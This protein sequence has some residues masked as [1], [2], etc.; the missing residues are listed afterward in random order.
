MGPL[1]NGI[2]AVLEIVLNMIQ[3]LVIA[4]IIVSWVGADQNN[5]F[6]RIIQSMT[7]PLF[8]PL[9]KFTKALPGPIDWAP[10]ILLLLI[11]FIQVGVIPYIRMMGTSGSPMGIP[12]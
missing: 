5:Q 10:M 8:R 9:R 2:A 12:G 1:A 7:E 3:L 11:V 6:V 4:S